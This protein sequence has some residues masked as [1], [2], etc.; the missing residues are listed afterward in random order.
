[1]TYLIRNNASFLVDPAKWERCDVVRCV[2]WVARKFGVRAPRR[3][4][5]PRCGADLLALDDHAWLQVC[6]GNSAAAR[7]FSAYVAHA[8]AS[9][10]GRPPPAPLPE[11]QA[12]PATSATAATALPE[13]YASL[14]NCAR[15][16]GSGGQVQLWQFLLEELAAGAPGIC[17]E[18]APGEGE[19]RLSDPDEVA[20]RW[21]RR[22]QKPNMNYDKLSR[23]LRYYYD[24]N[25]MT[26]VHGKRYAYRFCWAG[27][28]AACR[29]QD[30]P[31]CWRCPPPAPTPAPAPH[32]RS[33]PATARHAT[34][35]QPATLLEL[36]PSRTYY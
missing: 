34:S 19:F 3:S 11:H 4:L 33:T 5:L 8:H 10:T 24:K 2:R 30:A 15:A 18:G 21:G 13:P 23:A 1:M 6:E 36:V 28:A 35:A 29:A 17:W 7:I 12:A 22:K 26:K 25:I 16:G 9:A 32:P 20:R 31:P 14:S 27:L